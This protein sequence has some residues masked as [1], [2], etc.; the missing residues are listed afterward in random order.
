MTKD[1]SCAQLHETGAELA[2]GDALGPGAGRGDRPSGPL[3][4][5]PGAHRAACPRRRRSSRL[6]PVHIG[7]FT[8]HHGYGYWG[9]P[10]SVQLSSLS[11]VRLT[12]ADGRTLAT[13]DFTAR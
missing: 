4:G 3:R 9:A 1:L 7:T 12:S 13:A 6:L 8:L 11:G 5:L 2:L 10:A